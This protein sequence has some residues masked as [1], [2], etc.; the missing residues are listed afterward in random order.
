V[1]SLLWYLHRLSA[2]LA[3]STESEA[4][5]PTSAT[6]AP[7]RH[8]AQDVSERA[9]VAPALYPPSLEQTASVAKSLF[10]QH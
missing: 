5:V 4:A 1:F 6:Q 8:T 2:A 10:H 3:L 9:F 7:S